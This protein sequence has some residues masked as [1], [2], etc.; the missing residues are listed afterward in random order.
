MR[1]KTMLCAQRT[2]LGTGGKMK[3]IILLV[4]CFVLFTG[5]TKE[6]NTKSRAKITVQDYASRIVTLDKPAEKIIVMGDNAFVVVKQLNAIDK[7]IALD[8]KTKGFWNLYLM[9]KTNPEVADLPDVGKTK[10]PNY[11]YI[12]SLKPDLIL[13]KGN[14][15]A[16]DTLQNK[17]GIPVASIISK[18]G[19][20]FEIYNII[21]KLL[22]KEKEAKK[23]IEELTAK[24]QF[25]ESKLKIV[26]EFDRKSAYIVVQN[27]KNNLFW[28]H[29]NNLSLDMASIVNVAINA[30]RVDEW[31]FAEI[32]KEEFINWNP[33]FIYIDYPA[34]E[35][36]ISKQAIIDDEAFRF[37]ESVNRGNIFYTHSLAAPKDYVYI[38]AEAY[39]YARNAYPNIISEKDYKDAINDIFEKT[40]GIKDYYEDWKKSLH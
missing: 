16:A 34:S 13:F 28:T 40:Y 3:K 18:P 33:D 27:S 15:D 22:N 29:K 9:S 32:S 6:D 2:A 31:G 12:I 21:G 5:C 24:K 10:N 11:E 19:Y 4:I 7:V 35:K 1:F 20:D 14:K 23:V 17:T 26:S 38:I 39:Y 30:S 25:L 37:A 36:S 8:S